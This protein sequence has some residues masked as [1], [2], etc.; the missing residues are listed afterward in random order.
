[1]ALQ[2]LEKKNT[3]RNQFTGN[4][5]GKIN[6]YSNDERADNHDLSKEMLGVSHMHGIPV[7][8]HGTWY[9][10]WSRPAPPVSEGNK[11]FS[12]LVQD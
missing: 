6:N 4:I 7:C 11:G 3:D 8:E 2:I 5:C 10:E 12:F 1:M 9:A